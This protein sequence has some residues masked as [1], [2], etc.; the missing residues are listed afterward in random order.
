MRVR[1]ISDPKLVIHVKIGGYHDRA[2]ACR[3]AQALG[4]SGLDWD[5]DL[6]LANGQL[7]ANPDRGSSCQG[8]SFASLLIPH[9]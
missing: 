5:G 9:L 2:V 3:V 8:R 7:V 6:R 4:I 1:E